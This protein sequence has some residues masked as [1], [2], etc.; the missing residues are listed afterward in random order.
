MAWKSKYNNP[1][2][3]RWCKLYRGTESELSLE[4]AV[5]ALGIPYRTQFPGFMFG[6]RYFPDFVLPTLQVVIEVDDDSHNRKSKRVQDEERTQT[7]KEKFGWT[8][9]RC[10]NKEAKTDPVAAVERMLTEIGQYPIPEGIRS[11][12]VAEFLP[13]EATM[14]RGDKRD[15]KSKARARRRG[16]ID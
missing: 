11:L 4:D 5:A 10:T 7:L 15:A 3:G 14:P 9:V 12:R 8:V 2:A 13:N 6:I 1:M 16:T